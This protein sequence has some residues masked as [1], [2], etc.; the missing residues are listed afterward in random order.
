MGLYFLLRL[1]S[2]QAWEFESSV[3]YLSCSQD[4]TLLHRY[5][6]C[7]TWNLPEQFSQFG[8]SQPLM[9]LW[10]R[11][12]LWTS[13]S[14]SVR[15]VI[16]APG[17]SRSSRAPS[18]TR[19]CRIYH[20]CPLLLLAIRCCIGLFCQQLFF[21]LEI[22]LPRDPS[23]IVV[24][25]FQWHVPSGSSNPYSAQIFLYTIPATVRIRSICF[26]SYYI[27]I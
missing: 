3:Q 25:P 2:Y 1:R 21:S 14:S 10:P 18:S 11:G 26:P 8:G 4:C 6:R 15:L 12:P 23:S 22:E 27:Y 9:L 17:T 13:P 7:C 19:D 20:H 16:L 5:F 24:K